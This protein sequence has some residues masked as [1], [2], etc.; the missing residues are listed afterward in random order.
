MNPQQHIAHQF[1]S[2]CK[3]ILKYFARDYAAKEKRIEQERNLH[4]QSENDLAGLFVTD[5]YFED[6]YH[7]CV[8][9]YDISITDEAL[10]E[11]LRS[12]PADRRDIILLSFYLDM[13]DRESGAITPTSRKASYRQVCGR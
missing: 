12:L 2:Y 1:D 4:E 8:L 7:F 11:A 13:P 5:R 9:D 3:Q 6:A 10:A